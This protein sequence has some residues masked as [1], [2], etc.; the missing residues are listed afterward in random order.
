[1]DEVVVTLDL[2]WAPDFAIDYAA[3]RL[4]RANA[5]ATWFVTHASPAVDRLREHPDLFELGIHPN[6]LAGSTHGDTPE[7]VLEHCLSIVPEATS[8]RSHGLF[9]SSALLHFLACESQIAADVSLFLPR[10]TGLQPVIFRLPGGA[11]TRLPYFW[12]DDYEMLQPS[13][14]WEVDSLLMSAGLKIFDFHPIHIY[15][16]GSDFSSYDELKRRT[17]GKINQANPGDIDDLIRNGAGPRSIFEEILERI[18]GGGHHIRDI[19][20]PLAWAHAGTEQIA[21]A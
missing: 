1:M 20:E 21:E 5:K 11:L 10:A 4:T 17:G 9:Q 6:F 18:A 2:D 3:D 14:S 19:V 16:N 7:A 12:E 8:S 13:P 15:L